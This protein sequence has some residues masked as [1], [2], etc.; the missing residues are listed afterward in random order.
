LFSKKENV[1]NVVEYPITV[2][3]Q[4]PVTGKVI[5]PGF[6]G[7]VENTKIKFPEELGIQHPFDF[8]TLQKLYKTYGLVTG[9]VDKYI[10][11]IV[12]PGFFVTSEDKEKSGQAVQ[13]IEDFMRDVN[14]DTLLRDWLREALLKGNGF[15]ELGG[16]DENEA[17]KG[18]KLLNANWMYVDRDDKGVVTGYNQYVGGFEKFAKKKVQSFESFQ[19]AHLP[20]C[21]PGDDVYGIGII[22]P[23]LKFID[24]LIQNQKDLHMLMSRK[25]NAPLQV[26]LGAVVGGKYFKPSQESITKYGKDLE[27]MNNKHEWATDGLTEMKVVDFGNI[28]EKFNEVLN[29]DLEMVRVTIQIPEVLWGN[30]VNMAVAPVQMDAFERRIKSIQQQTEKVI[31]N[32]IFRRVLLANGLD[33]HVEFNWGKLSTLQRD[34]QLTKMTALINSNY[35]SMSLRR[36]AE[37]EIV[38]LLEFDE[39]EF[40][41]LS[42]KEEK[43]RELARSQPL[44]PGQNQGRPVPVRQSL[45]GY[46]HTDSCGCGCAHTESNKKWTLR[47]W[48]GFNYKDYVKQIGS[49]IS[50]YD[51]EFLVANTQIEAEAG[52]LSSTQIGELRGVMKN[53]FDKGQS[54]EE[55][56]I[57]IDK[58]VKPGDLL[59]VEDNKIVKKDGVPVLIKGK[60]HRAIGIARTETTKIANEGAK[61]QFKEGGVTHVRWVASFGQRTC[62]ECEGLDGA[63]FPIDNHPSIPIHG[64]CRCMLVP[65]TT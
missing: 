3:E 9:S 10:D 44:V 5:N 2:V 42:E 40:E 31:E 32:D 23:A 47:E 29:H 18:V 16:K 64:M 20:L 54:L 30:S 6:E 33:V 58:K 63:V 8:N 62:P 48:L 53:G 27:W 36:L 51:F 13:I 12:G 28:G 7:K 38:K 26:K 21:I 49:F 41:D 22:S 11:F 55:M 4:A 35:T 14:F 60:E 52:K 46:E 43:E 34:N 24:A 25:A 65:V 61:L 57:N 50:E 39:Q 17:P 1:S 19:I 56:A 45:I 15:L 37:R 59:K